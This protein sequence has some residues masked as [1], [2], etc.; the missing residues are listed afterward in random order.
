[1]IVAYAEQSHAIELKVALI[2]AGGHLIASSN[3]R[4]LPQL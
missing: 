2:S 3:C 1:M 4:Q